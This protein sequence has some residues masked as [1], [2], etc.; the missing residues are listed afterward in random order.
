MNFFGIQIFD[1]TKNISSPSQLFTILQNINDRVS[2]IEFFNIDI[3][4]LKSN[5]SSEFNHKISIKTKTYNTNV[6]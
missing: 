3:F 2:F 1:F 5:F 4:L 6:I